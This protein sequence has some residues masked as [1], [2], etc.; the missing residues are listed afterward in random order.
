M[1]GRVNP[2][3]SYASLRNRFLFAFDGIWA[4]SSWAIQCVL[5]GQRHFQVMF[6]V[7]HG[8]SGPEQT[9]LISDTIIAHE[10]RL[11]WANL[12]ESGRAFASFWERTFRR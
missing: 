6:G 2:S 7:R 3:L 12:L 4:D 1:F 10:L 8:F 5:A 9:Q 11:Q